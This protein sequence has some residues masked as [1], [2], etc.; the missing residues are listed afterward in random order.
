MPHAVGDKWIDRVGRVYD[1]CSPHW[2]VR[3]PDNGREELTVSEMK[4]GTNGKVGADKLN[5]A[6]E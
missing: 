6:E 1:L 3:F 4:K 5:K 2:R